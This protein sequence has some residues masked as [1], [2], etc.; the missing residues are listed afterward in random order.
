MIEATVLYGDGRLPQAAVTTSTTLKKV[1]LRIYLA[2]VNQS[3]EQKM[4]FSIK[5]FFS[6][7]EQI[8]RKQRFVHIYERHP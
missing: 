7:S 4:K 2:N 3:V 5:N 6:K 8:H 1:F